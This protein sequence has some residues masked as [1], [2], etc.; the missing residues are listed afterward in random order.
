MAREGE[1]ERER[2]SERESERKD[3]SLSTRLAALGLKVH[4][5]EYRVE[6]TVSAMAWLC[7]LYL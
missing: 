6:C 1:G 7:T 3:Q 5:N 4:F 2:E